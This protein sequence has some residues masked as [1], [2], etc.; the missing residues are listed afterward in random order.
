MPLTEV[1]ALFSTIKSATEIA[2]IVRESASTLE[3]A[4]TQ[5]KLAELTSA[6]ADVKMQAAEVQALLTERDSRIQAL[7]TALKSRSEMKWREPAYWM[8]NDAGE[9]HPFCQTCYDGKG[10]L[11]RLHDRGRGLF[12]CTVCGNAFRSR[13]RI[14]ADDSA[15]RD[16]NAGGMMRKVTRG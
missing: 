8:S 10:L 11:S 5:L 14:A 16:H 12:A 3:R 7:E 13:D 1:A 2:K 4:E 15:I 9:E 6:L